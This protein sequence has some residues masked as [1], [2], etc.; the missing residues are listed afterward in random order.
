MTYQALQQRWTSLKPREQ[1]G[2]RLAATVIG[3]ALLWS[4]L[5]GPALRTLQGAP[6]QHARLDAQM[7]RMLSLR[8][9]AEAL[10]SASQPAP[11]AAWRDALKS[12]VSLLGSAQIDEK[13]NAITVVLTDSSPQALARWLSELSQWQL[14]VAQAR[15]QQDAQGLWQGQLTLQHP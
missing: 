15:L 11:D 13:G 8:Q 10:R 6:A 4:L 7:Q 5:L 3:L 12:S 1:T 9:H 14:Q 2:L